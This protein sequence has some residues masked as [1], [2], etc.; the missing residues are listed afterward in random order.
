MAVV[1]KAGVTMTE[2]EAKGQRFLEGFEAVRAL[3]RGDVVLRCLVPGYRPRLATRGDHARAVA[4]AML[5]LA[6]GLNKA[7]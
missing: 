6:G 2:V 4:A 5:P 1:P 3:R 7:A